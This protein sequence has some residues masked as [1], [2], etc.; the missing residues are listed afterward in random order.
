MALPFGNMI[1][2]AIGASVSAAKNA[3]SAK[4]SQNSARNSGVLNPSSGSSFQDISSALRAIQ[5]S[6]NAWS[7]QQAQKQMDFQ[8]ES[9]RE[10]MAF[11]RDEAEK[12]R[13][14]QEY[15]SN[16]AH[17]REIKDLKAAG[18]NPALSAMGG[19][20]AAVTSGST[21]SGYSS[22]GAMGETDTSIGPSLISLFGSLLNSQ[23]QI[24]NKALDAQTNLAVADKYTA[25][26][27]YAS[28]LQS[29][30]QLTTANISSMAT[31]YAAQI[32]AGATVSSA[33]IHA[34]ATKVAASI[35]AAAQRYGYDVSAM[36]QRQIAA[37]NA[38][39]NKDLKSM[40]IRSQFDIREQYPTNIYGAAA[41]IGK[42]IGDLFDGF[43]G[44]D[45]SKVYPPG[46]SSSDDII[47]GFKY[48]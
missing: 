35:N 17:Q 14:W 4:L 3:V 5:Q 36:T 15:M 44:K 41:S 27:R 1:G 30:T 45:A 7:A 18:L 9:A 20:G 32:H 34:D 24:A 28:E 13:K 38:Q 10:A 19:N 6:N 2:S 25:T 12:S 21:A 31:R 33:Q 48:R 42:W 16:T 11:N 40:D 43:S 47:D 23:T 37:F 26:T 8:R 46:Y 39:V 22:Q 29:K